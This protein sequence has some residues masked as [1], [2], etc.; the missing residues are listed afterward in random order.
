MTILKINTLESSMTARISL[1]SWRKYRR[2]REIGHQ[3]PSIMRT[4]GG[5]HPFWDARECS[6]RLVRIRE[7]MLYKFPARGRD[8]RPILMYESDCCV[9]TT[10]FVPGYHSVNV[11]YVVWSILILHTLIC[12][13]SRRQILLQPATSNPSNMSLQHRAQ[14]SLSQVFSCSPSTPR[15]LNSINA[16]DARTTRS[17][18]MPSAVKQS[19]HTKT[20]TKSSCRQT[21]PKPNSINSSQVYLYGGLPLCWQMSSSIGLD[22]EIKVK[23]KNSHVPYVIRKRLLGALAPQS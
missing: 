18:K 16:Y 4:L 3:S 9:H 22:M 10:W 6:W 11:L 2:N 19:K 17:C 13:Y 1:E 14:D 23:L 15:M 5:P 8:I 7:C 20:P 21:W 12:M